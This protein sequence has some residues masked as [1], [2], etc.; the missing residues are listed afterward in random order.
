MLKLGVCDNILPSNQILREYVIL[1][2][3]LGGGDL[4]ESINPEK[5]LTNMVNAKNYMLQLCDG[6]SYLHDLN[7]VHRDIKPE[8]IA[9]TSDLSCLKI[10]DF[11]L[12]E[13]TVPKRS[14]KRQVGTV[15]YM[16][17]ELW[18]DLESEFTDTDLKAVDVWAFGVVFFTI[19][20]GRFPWSQA[21]SESEEYV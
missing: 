9:L 8:N 18:Y 4:Y 14:H 17:P 7:I 3:Y 5:G 21:S 13:F 19:L 12:S 10:I 6:L 2:E 15:P 11:G 20:T 1:Q 16:A